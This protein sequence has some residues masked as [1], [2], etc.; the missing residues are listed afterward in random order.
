MSANRF[1]FNSEEFPFLFV[2]S[3]KSRRLPFHF[4]FLF[5]FSAISK[6]KDKGTG[7]RSN[8]SPAQLSPLFS[9]HRRRLLLKFVEF[10]LLFF[11]ASFV[12]CRFMNSQGLGKDLHS[13]AWLLPF[14]VSSCCCSAQLCFALLCSWPAGGG[15]Q[16]QENNNENNIDMAWPEQVYL[17][18]RMDC[19]NVGKG[20]QACGLRLSLNYSSSSLGAAIS[21]AVSVSGSESASVSMPSLRIC[22]LHAPRPFSSWFGSMLFVCLC[23]P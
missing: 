15:G 17:N 19:C 6:H 10:F 23:F 2:W 13:G 20:F 3:T 9:L 4:L 18:C 12:D 7:Q 21:V 22:F 8:Q 11:H 5:L 16:C 14:A 1:G